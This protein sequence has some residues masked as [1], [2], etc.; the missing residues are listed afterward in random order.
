MQARPTFQSLC[1]Y[2]QSLFRPVLRT[3]LTGF[4][5][6]VE[7]VAIVGLTPILVSIELKDP[8]ASALF[9]LFDVRLKS[10]TGIWQRI[11]GFLVGFEILQ[12]QI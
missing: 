9:K 2:R 10:W 4:S 5:F 1:T 8:L 11:E 7:N 3:K 12:G 6:D